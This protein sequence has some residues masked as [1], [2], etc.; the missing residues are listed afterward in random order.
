M[1]SF[2]SRFG[3]NTETMRHSGYNSLQN[4]LNSGMTINEIRNLTQREGVS[5]GGRAQDFLNQ[6]GSGSFIAQYG[7]NANTMSN[8]GMSSVNRA[9][10]A[11]MSWEDIE[12]RGQ[13][14][15][16]TWGTKAAQYF[17][18]QRKAKKKAE[19]DE[20]NSFQQVNDSINDPN[21]I[22]RTPDRN[23]SWIVRDYGND[24]TPDYAGMQ[25]QT[26]AGAKSG[27]SSQ[28][29][30]PQNPYSNA[31]LQ[32][33]IDKFKSGFKDR[34]SEFGLD[35]KGGSRASQGQSDEPWLQVRKMRE[36]R[37]KGYGDGGNSFDRRD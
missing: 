32:G 33:K 35:L 37:R 11:G 17:D 15:G 1:S 12:K 9:L 16:I 10:A 18:D 14:E 20:L 24:N 21:S 19:F 13:Q 8:S 36:D 34:R 4:A 29:S 22:Y 6:R 25:M 28:S 30:Q 3:G 31:F 2:I 23:K 5:F 7:G 27:S 26:P